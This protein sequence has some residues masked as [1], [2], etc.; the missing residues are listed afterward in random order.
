M[1][2]RHIIR[3]PEKALPICRVIKTQD[4]KPLLEIKNKQ[5]MEI[6][7]LL[8]LLEEIFKIFRYSPRSRDLTRGSR[9]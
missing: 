1:V 7:S 3:T 8:W 4:G 9:D 5:Q 6:V 2:D